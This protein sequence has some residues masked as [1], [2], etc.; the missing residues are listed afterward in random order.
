M[1]GQTELVALGIAFVLLTGT[2]AAGVVLADSSLASAER[3]ALERQTA[4][5][6]SERL[7]SEA[8]AHTA[9]ENVLSAGALRALNETILRDSYNIPKGTDVAISLSGVTV[10]ETGPTAEGT[11][12][13]RI[14]LIERR[15]NE[16]LRPEFD[17]SRTVTLPRRA[18]N[19]TLHIDPPP[20]TT[21]ESVAANGQVV[22]SNDSGLSGVFDV[23]L[24]SLQTTTFRFEAVGVLDEGSV[25]ITYRPPE[26][27][28]AR[29]RVSV[30]A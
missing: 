18:S 4:T 12:V 29:L 26:T 17:R 1:R 13:E 10:V 28:K 22:L 23:S 25:H 2:V 15:T 20:G 21:V 3:E 30:D 27:S 24:S 5:T 14:V 11:T 16:T 19:A 7:V 9:R 8:A 6:L